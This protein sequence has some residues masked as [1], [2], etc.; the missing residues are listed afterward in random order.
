M[1]QPELQHQYHIQKGLLENEFPKFI[2]NYG[3]DHLITKYVGTYASDKINSYIPFAAELRRRHIIC[4][5]CLLIPIEET[6]TGRI[7]LV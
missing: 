6:K 2:Y 4:L 1:S 7:G 3:R 5:L